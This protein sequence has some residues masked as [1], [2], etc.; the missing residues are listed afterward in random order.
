MLSANERLASLYDSSPSIF[1]DPLYGNQLK[2]GITYDIMTSPFFHHFQFWPRACTSK[3]PTVLCEARDYLVNG[4]G[5]VWQLSSANS[6]EV[7]GALSVLY[8]CSG[9]CSPPCGL[10]LRNCERDGVC[11][12][13]SEVKVI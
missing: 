5:L 2:N 7:E 9:L 8:Q 11:D 3:D 12:L 10:M 6:L 1:V 13:R 4:K